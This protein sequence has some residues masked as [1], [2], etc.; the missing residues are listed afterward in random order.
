MYSSEMRDYKQLLLIN[1][2][3]YISVNNTINYICSQTIIIY[4][5]KMFYESQYS[6]V[7]DSGGET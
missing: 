1:N 7:W 3:I 6:I 2:I 4:L 5:I